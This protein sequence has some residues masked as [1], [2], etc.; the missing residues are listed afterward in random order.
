MGLIVQS[1]RPE[2]ELTRGDLLRLR[3]SGETVETITG[4]GDMA[5]LTFTFSNGDKVSLVYFHHV[6]EHGMDVRP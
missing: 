6:D 1:T 2:P 3:L 5:G 4:Q